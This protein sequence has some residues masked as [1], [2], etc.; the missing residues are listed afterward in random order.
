[1]D[2]PDAEDAPPIQAVIPHPMVLGNSAQNNTSV[3]NVPSE[4]L[5][6]WGQQCP[7]CAQSTPSLKMED[8]DWEEEDWNG[9][10]QKAK[11]EER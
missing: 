8:F 10:R 7:I 1:M 6:G 11:E 4:E 5:C 2:R 3:P 9:D